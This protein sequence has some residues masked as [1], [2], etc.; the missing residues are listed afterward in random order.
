MEK[1]SGK[2]KGG[3]SGVPPKR[4]E[5]QLPTG[6]KPPAAAK[7]DPKQKP[8][9]EV[10]VGPS[11][12]T[13]AGWHSIES[14]FRCEKEYQ[15]QHVRKVAQPQY[16]LPDHFAVGSLFHAAR[17]RW[18]ALRFATDAK[19]WESI[20]D[21]VKKEAVGERLPVTLKAEQLTLNIFAQYMEHWSHRVLPTPM[22]AEYEVGPAPLEKGD[23]FFLWRT[24]R[25]DDVSKYPDGG[26]DLWIGEAKTG[27][28]SVS[29]IINTYELHGQPLLQLILWKMSPQGEA[30]HG[31]VKG[32]M[33]D[34]VQK[35]YGGDKCAF[36][37]QGIVVTEHSLTWYIRSFK[38]KLR[39]LAQID[40]DTDVDRNISSCIRAVGRGKFPCPYRDLCKFGKSASTNFVM[41]GQSLLKWLP[42]PGKA[43]APWE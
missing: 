27:S 9:Q 6:A 12:P 11:G 23:P 38:A 19:A 43:V 4:Q 33:L 32:V 5:V 20:S 3:V 13:S 16:Q 2:T 24:A 30:K 29:S 36:G 22:L 39:R 28:D 40:W 1:K 35:G 26:K 10:I 42:S 8:L 41:D 31:P 21:A 17:A 18:F 25:L 34:A 14:G 37:R 7:L 15:F